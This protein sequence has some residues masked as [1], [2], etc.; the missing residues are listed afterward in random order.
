MSDLKRHFGQKAALIAAVLS[1][2]LTVPAFGLFVWLWQTRGSGDSWV[3]SALTTV[4]FLAACAVVLYV[5]SLPR[6]RLPI[7]DTQARA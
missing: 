5:I 1:A 6:P 7:D 4:V 2:L 3:P